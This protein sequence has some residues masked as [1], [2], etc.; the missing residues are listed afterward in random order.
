MLF[1]VIHKEQIAQISNN[2][3]LKIQINIILIVL[4][5]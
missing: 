2:A 3:S 1:I 4:I 5:L